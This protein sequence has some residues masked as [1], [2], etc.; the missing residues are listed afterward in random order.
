V[1]V[2]GVIVLFAGEWTIQHSFWFRPAVLGE[3]KIDQDGV[4]LQSCGATCAAWPS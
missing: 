4:V 3:A 1:P 2:A